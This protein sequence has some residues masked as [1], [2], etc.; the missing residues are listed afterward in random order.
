MIKQSLTVI[1]LWTIF[2]AFVCQTTS[3]TSSNLPQVEPTTEDSRVSR[4]D[5]AMNVR[6]KKALR[7]AYSEQLVSEGQAEPLI[8]EQFSKSL[9]DDWQISALAEEEITDEQVLKDSP[10]MIVGRQFKNPVVQKVLAQLPFQ[11][12]GS[13][14]TFQRQV[15]K[16]AAL[17]FRLFLYPNPLSKT[18]VFYIGGNS[19][20]AINQQLQHGEDSN[21][22]GFFWGGWG[23]EI[24]NGSAVI[25]RGNFKDK[26]WTFDSKNHFDFSQQEELE[27]TS[28]HFR[29]VDYANLGQQF[30]EN[31]AKACEAQIEKIR[32]FTRSQKEILPI[33]YYLYPS[34]EEK[35][36][37]LSNTREGQ[38][39]EKKREVHVVVNERFKGQ[40]TQQDI[41]LVLHD[42]IGQ[43]STASI[44]DGLAAHF[45]PH[46]QEKGS[47][48]WAT[49]LYQSNNLPPLAELMDDEQYQRE[50]PLVMTAAAGSFVSFLIKHWG[51]KKFL[52]FYSHGSGLST[53]EMD[54]LEIDWHKYL[55]QTTQT[56]KEK[57]STSLP[58]YQG[59]NFAHEGYQIYNGYG[60][61]LAKASLEKLQSLGTNAVAIVPYG[62]Q[63]NPRTPSFLGVQHGAGSEND[64]SVI[65]AH[66]E[67]QKLGMYT[68]MKPQLWI[69]GSWPGD[70]EMS[71]DSG[72]DQFFDYYYRWIRHYAMIAEIRQF[73]ALCLG[74]EFSIATRGKPDAWRAI[75]KKIRGLY[76]GPIT[77]A[78]NWGE[79]FEQL[80][81]WDELD[82]IG[83]NCYY[84]LSDKEAVDKRELKQAFAEVL[85]KAE[86]VSK[87]YNKPLVLT[88]VGFR[89]VANSWKNPHAE[90]SGRS[91]DEECQRICYEVLFEGIQDKEWIKGLFLWKWPS[92][93]EYRQGNPK[94]FS[95][96]GKE[97]EEVVGKWFGG[98]LKR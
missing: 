28:T 60:S 50:S 62:Y 64:E 59:F 12:F 91:A 58:Y 33:S 85:Q 35:G 39:L 89:S 57:A 70:V 65:Y 78:A 20:E 1:V 51:Q 86:A 75:I 11:D 47:N 77:Y 4:R 36:L 67:A 88:E 7:I 15:Y 79:E 25:V 2:G 16:Q 92:Y 46:W 8:V 13:H 54:L 82:F 43:G 18:P 29:F 72:W 9:P 3:T 55:E 87:R 84:P 31:L 17:S 74:V 41:Q 38:L 10:L 53:S 94:G 24:Y 32:S 30:V 5:L 68:L 26:D 27:L 49:R 83:L 40:H 48:H 19:T 81:F 97:A 69:N 34:I 6:K 45:S 76:S 63:R 90:A 44:D 52:A 42:L 71:D 56:S 23:Y 14:F 80:S 73:D 21:L 96:T 61:K 93:L 66:L 98:K 95:P 22:G 37:R